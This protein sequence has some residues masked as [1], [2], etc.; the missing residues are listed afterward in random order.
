MTKIQGKSEISIENRSLYT[1]CNIL[2]GA[3]FPAVSLFL[4]LKRSRAKIIYIIETM[5]VYSPPCQY[6]KLSYGLFSE[7]KNGI[8]DKTA[9]VTT[10]YFISANGKKLSYGTTGAANEIQI[11]N[12]NIKNLGKM[13]TRTDNTTF[14][15]TVPVTDIAIITAAQ[16]KS[17]PANIL[18]KVIETLALLS[19]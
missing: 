8:D 4:E 7:P 14:E 15:N 19:T 11:L 5:R 18:K 6:V 17:D 12:I 1:F 10:L 2:L 13:I 16:V 3:D 9:L